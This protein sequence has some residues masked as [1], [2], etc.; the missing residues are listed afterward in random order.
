MNVYEASDEVA[1]NEEATFLILRDNEQLTVT[2]TKNEVDDRCSFGIY[3]K[4][5]TVINET[6]VG[7]RVYQTSTGGPSGG[8][9][10]SLYVFNALTSKDYTNG[11]KIGG[12]GTIDVDGNVGYIGGVRQKI[13]TAIGNNIDIFFVPYL[14]DEDGD[15]YIEALKAMEEFDSDMILVGVSTIDEAI[16]Y[17][18][19]YGDNNG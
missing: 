17:L 3:L 7:Y 12:T 13:I 1:C 18:E 8:L 5:L 16:E 9:M 2:A 19:D 11:L 6:T 10:Q 15:N 4:P 14:N